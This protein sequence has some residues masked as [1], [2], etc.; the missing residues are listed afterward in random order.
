MSAG[1]QAR[2]EFSG[3]A[4]NVVVAG[5]DVHG[6]VHFHHAA[7]PPAVVPR[8]LPRAATFFTDRDEEQMT[9]ER[10]AAG[11]AQDGTCPIIV[12]DGGG[13]VGK[14]SLALRWAHRAAAAL[15]YPD[16]Q[17]YVDLQGH[18]SADPVAVSAALDWMLRGVGIDPGAVPVDLE[19]RA[20]LYQSVMAGRRRLVLLDNAGPS[21][22]IKYLFPSARES[23]VLV[24]SRSEL[25]ALVA[26]EGAVRVSIGVLSEAAAVDLLERVIAAQRPGEDRGALADLASLCAR[27]PLALRIAGEKL[28]A[29]PRVPL[30]QFLADLRDESTRFEALTVRDGGEEVAV[31]TVFSWSYRTLDARSAGFFRR[32]GLHS[33]PQFTVVTVA[34][35]EAI[36]VEEARRQFDLLANAHLVQQEDDERYQFHDLL[37]AY[38]RDQAYEEDGKERCLAY[39]RRTVVWYLRSALAAGRT[40]RAEILELPAV[41]GPSEIDGLAFD[42]YADAERWC[43]AERHALAAAVAAAERE[44]W[45]ELVWC[46][47]AAVFCV[48]QMV[49]AFDEWRTTT[50]RGL[51]AARRLADRFGQAVMLES[52][53]KLERQTHRLA[54]AE[55]AQRQALEIRLE[56]DDV[57]GQIRSINALGLVYRRAERF[58][59]ARGCFEKARNLARTHGQQ[60]LLAFPVMNL[61]ELDVQTGRFDE[62]EVL[63]REALEILRTHDAGL[64]EVNALQDLSRALLG[65]G[66]E[67]EARAAAAQAVAKAVDLHS[68]VFLAEALRAQAEVHRATGDPGRALEQYSEITDIQRRLGDLGRQAAVLDETG[69]TY[70][71][72]SRPDQAAPFHRVAA[73]IYHDLGDTIRETRALE[74]LRCAEEA[75]RGQG[76]GRE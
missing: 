47:A 4:D 38:A 55:D 73:Q 3:S 61:G 2:T 27:L 44:G 17:L 72:M 56:I 16:G 65:L 59:D 41:Q 1:Q 33:E 21:P 51:A 23:V 57:P 52:L 12:I 54:A 7:A 6:G 40:M 50:Q 64:Y 63:L 32:L 39:V 66:R 11:E 48:L 53:G 35:L 26:Q 60:V 37:R 10:A 19:A 8:Q 75:A 36:P 13:G 29:R 5:G 49:N 71:E 24:T 34:A 18:G 20:A 76:D 43:A 22:D 9:I 15:R 68:E 67:D 25:R 58:D 69:L 62:A 31:R 74:H 70:G 28:A 30:G 45:D 46:L 14:T 42:S